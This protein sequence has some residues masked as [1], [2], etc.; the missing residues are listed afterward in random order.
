MLQKFISE[1]RFCFAAA[2]LILFIPVSLKVHGAENV[3]TNWP[4]TGL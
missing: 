4:Q 2:Y 3:Q 1:I